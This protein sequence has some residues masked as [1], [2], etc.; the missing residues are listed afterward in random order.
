MK[1]ELLTLATGI[2]HIK[3]HHGDPIFL[4]REIGNLSAKLTLL[5]R[6]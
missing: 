4:I 2:D 3:P 5:E 1:Q 6:R